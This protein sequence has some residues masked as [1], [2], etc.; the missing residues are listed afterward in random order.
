MWT[1]CS[2]EAIMKIQ[3]GTNKNG[4]KDYLEFIKLQIND[5]VEIVRGELNGWQRTLMGALIVLDDHCR[6][7]IE[8][9]VASDV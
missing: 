7:V 5:M 3:N 9:M 8:S 1:F 2:T 6:T 4:L